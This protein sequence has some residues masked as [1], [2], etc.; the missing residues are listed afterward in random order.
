M[1]RRE[2]HTG[3]DS[4]KDREKHRGRGIHRGRGQ[5]RAQDRHRARD[6]HKN[7]RMGVVASWP[8]LRPHRQRRR[9]Q[10]Q[11]LHPVRRPPRRRSRLRYRHPPDRRRQNAAPDHR[12]R[13]TP[14]S[15][16]SALLKPHRWQF[17]AS[18]FH[19]FCA[20][21][22]IRPSH[23]HACRTGLLHN[24]GGDDFSPPMRSHFCADPTSARAKAVGA[25]SDVLETRST[26]T[27][28]GL[29]NPPARSLAESA[30]SSMVIAENTH[31]AF[32]AE[33]PTAHSNGA[34]DRVRTA[35]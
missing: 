5:G 2:I 17:V 4:H 22:R 16:I 10:R 19:S 9:P 7:R 28:K 35:G 30:M 13:Y 23:P 12:G 27:G 32:T 1:A 33:D 29:Y 3:R 15:S 31:R 8:S 26:P 24:G 11:A 20:P 6:I 25:G 21:D 18:Q 14:P 34:P